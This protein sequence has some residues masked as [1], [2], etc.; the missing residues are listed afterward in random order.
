MNPEDYARELVALE[1]RPYLR[2]VRR[3]DSRGI[4]VKVAPQDGAHLRH[5]FKLLERSLPESALKALDW[6]GSFLVFEDFP[7]LFLELVGSRR[8]RFELSAVSRTP[9]APLWLS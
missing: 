8:R 4:L 9:G 6:Q 7:G 3:D 1:G 5:E 2:G